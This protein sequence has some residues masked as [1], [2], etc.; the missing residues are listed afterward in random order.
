MHLH[1]KCACRL[2]LPF[3]Y[4]SNAP[5]RVL[6]AVSWLAHGELDG[7]QSDA[8][9]PPWSPTKYKLHEVKKKKKTTL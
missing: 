6:T 3:D 8:S 1:Q 2:L 7:A 5:V 4:S 9:L